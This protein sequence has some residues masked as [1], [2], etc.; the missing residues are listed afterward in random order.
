MIFVRFNL[1]LVLIYLFPT[2]GEAFPGWLKEYE[3]KGYYFMDNVYS[4]SLYNRAT[5]S[6]F[7]LE[8]GKTRYGISVLDFEPD[9]A[10]LLL[11]L[12]DQTGTLILEST[13]D[14][15]AD[16]IT[17]VVID[18]DKTQLDTYERAIMIAAEYILQNPGADPLEAPIPGSVRSSLIQ[19]RNSSNS[20]SKKDA[21]SFK[22][23]RS[24]QLEIRRLIREK[25]KNNGTNA[26]R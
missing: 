14:F 8:Q 25:Q 26:L 2:N 11:S 13:K 7:W 17:T 21:M 4:F 22:F 1:V 3:F 16:N 6:S 15:V 18:H 9:T 19:A 12:N 5:A 24:V 23:D 10:T 20:S